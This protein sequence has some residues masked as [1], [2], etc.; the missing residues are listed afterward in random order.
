MASENWVESLPID[1][2]DGDWYVVHTRARNEKALA[3]DLDVRGIGYFLPLVRVRRVYGGRTSFVDLPLFPGYLF[4]CG[5]SAER[6]ATLRTNRVASILSVCDQSRIRVELR[7][8]YRTTSGDVP[9]DL[10]PGIRTGRLCRVARGSLK[11]L[12][13]VVL[14]RRSVCRVYVGIEVLGQSAELELDP[15]LLELID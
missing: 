10:Y 4:L 7:H 9:V 1:A 13:G 5:G 14:R 6:E 15:G 2:L 3:A 12:E 11:G 8:V